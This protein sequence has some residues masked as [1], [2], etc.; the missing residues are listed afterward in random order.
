[1]TRSYAKTEDLRPKA[2]DWRWQTAS[3]A[4]MLKELPQDTWIRYA[5]KFINKSKLPPRIFAFIDQAVKIRNDVSELGERVWLEGFILA[6]EDSQN[7][8]DEFGYSDK[9]LVEVYEKLFFDIRD[10]LKNQLYIWTHVIGTSL[11]TLTGSFNAG[12]FIRAIGYKEKVNG[13]RMLLP[14]LADGEAENLFRQMALQQASLKAVISMFVAQPQNSRVQEMLISIANQR[15]AQQETKDME[16][17]LLSKLTNEKL[18]VF[19]REES[20]NQLV[21]GENK[22]E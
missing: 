21:V 13:L 3:S 19:E 16:D 14:C 6:G 1:M 10:R 9:M 12:S 11:S 18:T 7:I 17:M 4:K 2:P 20:I 22:N 5:Y 8:A 15:D